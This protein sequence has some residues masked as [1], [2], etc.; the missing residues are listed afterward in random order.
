MDISAV[1]CSAFGNLARRLP[2]AKGKSRLSRYVSH[3]LLGDRQSRL[4]VKMNDGFFL[5]L[6]PRSRTESGAFC[7]GVYDRDDLDF[8]KACLEPNGKS[9]VLDIGANIG[10]ITVPLALFV[11]TM[12]KVLSFEP[13]SANAAALRTNVELN[14]LSGRVQVIECALGVRESTLRIGREGDHGA[15][16]GNAYLDGSA[17][18][19]T[20]LVWTTV[21]VR[22]LD[23]VCNELSIENITLIKMDVEG[24]EIDVLRGA[25]HTL[26]RYRP[27]IYGEFQLSLRPKSGQT[28]ADVDAI[29]EGLNYKPFAFSDRLK[30]TP[31]S[32]KPGVGNVVLCP[33]EKIEWLVERCRLRRSYT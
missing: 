27:I 22:S 11:G 19:H 2:R 15:T 16:T 4:I 28:F 21:P 13:V 14:S 30:L 8:F 24:A 18:S 12:G 23:H 3:V 25:K 6:D 10:L 5:S 26:Q 1:I 31:V 32:Y 9:V 33:G 7:D 17:G 20:A 29:F